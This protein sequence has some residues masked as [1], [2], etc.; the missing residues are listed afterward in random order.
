[1]RTTS[2]PV[3]QATPLFFS[4]PAQ[5]TALARER[6]FDSGDRPSGLVSEAVL[7]SW[8][9]CLAA[10]QSPRYAVAF[11]AVTRAR[12]GAALERSQALLRASGDDITRLETALAGTG[13]SVLLTDAQGV[14]VHAT[15]NECLSDSPLIRLAGR[16]GVDLSEGQLGTNAPAVVVKTQQAV[17]VNGAEHFFERVHPLHCAA[18]PI[19][20]GQGRLAGVLD[21]TVEAR[22]F[23]FDAAALVGVYA[24][25]IENR[26]LQATTAGCLVLHFQV[27][28]SML[29][30]PLEALVGINEQG[31]VAWHNGTAQ[32]LLGLE[33][34]TTPAAGRDAE[35]LFGV[36]LSA[37]LALTRQSQASPLR[38]PNGLTVWVQAKAAAAPR[39]LL[40]V[41][42]RP[43]LAPGR[44]TEASEVT[45]TTE[46]T[47]EPTPP[48]TAVA[49][50]SST[51]N[52]VT[53]EVIV[54]TLTECDG[55]VSRA[56]R[57]LGVSRGLLYRRLQQAPRPPQFP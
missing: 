31:H 14:I 55:N 3:S 36:K 19:R 7:Q 16:V 4:T 38:L 1:M 9:R 5:R 2:H 35:A 34:L 49:P 39:R 22:P 20:D 50:A 25:M 15:A 57:R 13:A 54:R 37:L 27:C 46:A 30:S 32:K 12:L 24:T 40:S 51:L 10:R 53:G 47:S 18:A 44:T 48:S 41:S 33:P 29:G 56:A 21:L 28:S 42:E 52:Q 45:E 43:E 11:E 17:T 26:L 6:F 8:G 23:A